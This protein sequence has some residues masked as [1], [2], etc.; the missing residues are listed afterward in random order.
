MTLG[1]S[2]ILFELQFHI[3]TMKLFYLYLGIF[4]VLLKL[5]LQARAYTTCFIST[6]LMHPSE[7]EKTAEWAHP[8][9]QIWEV[10]HT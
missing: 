5:L 4:L 3:F 2:H 6:K 7:S 10:F 1:K 8:G 9:V